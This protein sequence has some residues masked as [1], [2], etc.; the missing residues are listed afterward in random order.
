MPLEARTWIRKM[1]GGAQAH[2][3]TAQDG[4]YYVVKCKQNPQHRR[5]LVNELV[6]SVLLEY[7]R[8]PSPKVEMIRVSEDFL[9]ENPQMVITHGNHPV[10]IIPGWHF[11]SRMPVDPNRFA[12]YDYIPDALLRTVANLRDFVGTLVFDKWVHN[13]DARQCVFFRA[14]V[15]DWLAAEHWP[16]KVAFVALM[17]DHGYI[18]GGPHWELETSPL[19][20]LYSRPIVYDSVTGFESFQPWLDLVR[21]F[22][23]DILDKAFRQIPEWWLNGDREALE[24]L[25]EK[26]YRRRTRVE[27]LLEDAKRGR[28]NPYP[29]WA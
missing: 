7:L 11:G 16:K 29:N 20:G 13:A 15:K 27:T 4:N 26:L 6:A 22:P 24:Q 2:L 17:M 14:Q 18:F 19:S 28:V 8:I 21:N 3:L 10:M 1:R 9:A 12:I 25:L 5:I 23:P